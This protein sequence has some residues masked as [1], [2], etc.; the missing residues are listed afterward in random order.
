[1]FNGFAGDAQDATGLVD[2]ND[3]LVLEQ[4]VEE[5][6]LGRIVVERAHASSLSIAPQ[7]G[8]RMGLLVGDDDKPDG[9]EAQLRLIQQVVELGSEFAQVDQ[10]GVAHG[11][12][13]GA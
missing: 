1:M 5:G 12:V 13:D 10:L 9:V 6:L 7:S 4:D 3:V 8:A 11:R 2:D